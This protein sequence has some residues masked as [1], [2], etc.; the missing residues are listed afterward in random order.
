PA[1]WSEA[2]AT[3][4]RTDLVAPARVL[5]AV[6]TEVFD[7][8]RERFAR[9]AERFAGLADGPARGTDA[10]GLRPAGPEQAPGETGR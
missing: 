10:A 2:V 4:S 5:A 7:R 1:E 6:A 9:R 3:A 8:D